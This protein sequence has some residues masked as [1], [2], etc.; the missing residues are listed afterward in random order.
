MSLVYNLKPFQYIH[1]LDRNTNSRR[2]LEGPVNYPI[3]DNETLIDNTIYDMIVISNLC[4][5]AILNP[6]ERNSKGE[7]VF[8]KFGNAKNK[9]GIQELRTRQ[10]FP[11]PFPLYPGEKLLFNK[12]MEFLEEGEA[13]HFKALQNVE[14]ETGKHSIGDEWIVKGPT[15]YGKRSEIEVVRKLKSI[16]INELNG[17]RVVATRNFKDKNG[18]NRIAGEEWLETQPGEYIPEVYTDIVN[19]VKGTVID[20]NSAVH[21]KALNNYVDK[22]NVKRL[23]GQEW[24]I[25]SNIAS[26]H[27]CDIYEELVKVEKRVVLK[28][29]QYCIIE[30]PF[31]TKTNKNEFGKLVQIIGESDFFLNPGEVMR[32]IENAYIL[33]E[34]DALLVQAVEDLNFEDK[35]IKC[36]D[37]WT[38]RGPAKYIPEINVKVVEKRNIIPLDKN[39]GIYIR[40]TATGEVRKH[41]G[42][43]YLLNS[44]EVLWE[45]EMHSNI[46]KIYLRDCAI[47][48]RDKTRV[49]TYKCPFNCVMQIYNL[50][51]KSNRIVLGPKLVL[52][53]P[54]EEFC[55]INLS[56]KT[57]KV[58]GIVETLYLKL[59]PSFSTDEFL[60]ETSDHTRL[61]LRIMYNWHW[62]VKNEKEA[63]DIFTVRNFVGD[64]C[65]TMASRIRSSIATINFEDFHKKSD[66]YIKKSVFG[67]KNGELLTSCRNEICRLVVND[68]DIKYIVPSEPSTK[69]LLEKS[70]S[71]AI[72]LTTKTIENDFKIQ[73]KIK[74]QEFIGELNKLKIE[75]DINIL[76]KSCEL[77][78][79]KVE[80]NIIEVT[81]LSRAQA[82]AKKDADLIVSKSLLEYEKLKKIS[83]ELDNDFNLKLKAKKNDN[84]YLRESENERINIKKILGESK[85]EVEKFKK[86]MEAIGPDTIVEIAKAGPELQAKLL[87]GLNLSGYILTDGNNPI[88]LFNV[89]NNLTSNNK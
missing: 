25:T 80:S 40:N 59:G 62:D 14:D 51:S 5:A 3:Q 16:I 83:L 84:E 64:L 6:I 88:N 28:A 23:A 47:T 75:N 17:V 77:I 79:H 35:I 69:E 13:L 15:Y 37:K 24:I 52:L 67:E 85:V 39:E 56:G 27:I 48:K 86:I 9:W 11:R 21:L 66:Y 12:S 63:E 58:E 49:V 18:K 42:S 31:N 87:Q 4:Q 70:V 68:V 81:G 45:K 57:P 71:L 44:N 26:T 74:E 54:D 32:N 55:L 34:N 29:N 10:Q 50:K 7:I 1:I 76:Q 73:A 30:N 33:T 46:E 60:V 36:G 82:M 22:Y 53:D 72:E 89:A 43:S 41:V 8:D 65:L 2:L 19:L 78:K 61:V 20:E 38:I